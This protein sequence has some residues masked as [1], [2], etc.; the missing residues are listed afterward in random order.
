M[1]AKHAILLPESDP[2]KTRNV[3]D[4]LPASGWDSVVFFIKAVEIRLRFI[5]ILI[6][7][8]LVIGYWETITNYWEKFTRSS[9]V[10]SALADGM[11]F[12]CPM[13]PNVVR[14]TLDPDGSVPDC[15]ICGMPLSKRKK[16]EPVKL[17]EGVLARVQLSPD[18]IQAGGIGSV[19]VE[20]KPL[21]K[22]LRTVGT[23]EYD[24]SRLS[25]IVARVDGY[26]EKLYVNES[27]AELR[28][29][30][31]IADIY[32]PE[33]YTAVQEL[34]LARSAKNEQLA[35]LA[36]EK[37]RL[38][39]IDDQDIDALTT[40]KDK[41]R[42]TLRSPRG[43]HLIRKEVVEGDKV[44]PG[45]VLF[46]VADL[47]QMW[48]EMEVY[49][50]DIAI[51]KPGMKVE[52]RIEAFPERVFPGGIE[53][54]HP[55]LQGDQRTVRV[56][57]RLDNS[58]HLLRQGMYATV[59]VVSPLLETEPF[60]SQLVKSRQPQG[61]VDDVALAAMQKVCPVTGF[62]LGSMGDPKRVNVGTR[63]VLLCCDGCMK[64]M[65]A[66][67]AE[68]L[69]R[70][71][72]VS[73][74]GVLAVPERA[75]IDTG[76]QK[77]VYVEREPGTFEGIEVKLGPRSGGYYA[78]IEGLLPGD[79]VAASGAFLIDAE[80]RLNP[81]ASAAYFGA[82]GGPQSGTTGAATAEPG[83]PGMR[84]LPSA[85]DLAQIGKLP[86]ADRKAATAQ[87]TCPITDEPL[88]SMG[89]PV[90]VMLEGKAVYLCC[91]GCVKK[92]ES[93]PKKTLD[94]IQGWQKE[95]TP[96]AAPAPEAT[97]PLAR[98]L[99]AAEDLTEIA[100]LP[101]ADRKAALAQGTCPITDEPLG[102][103]GVPLK[104]T[105]NGKAVY[106]CCKG[107]EKDAENEAKEVLQK[108]EAWKKE[109]APAKAHEGHG[110]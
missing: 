95:P 71:S 14:P 98:K 89:V 12:F 64:Q 48:L 1:S 96:K 97:K 55:H 60:H 19:A 6:G 15:P 41:V 40:S 20:Q 18:R 68:F 22:E 109:P 42:L 88:G 84:K 102:S 54:V 105:L 75:V 76:E 107:C 31:P 94:K 2:E 49:E 50:R 85:A 27:F 16:G 70:L 47:S 36:R 90:K 78:V 34:L 43:G 5:A 82:S 23:L 13:H 32:S 66:Q 77:I 7:M 33:L 93:E 4:S 51:I 61:T 21:V 104:V 63:D 17:R 86:E 28:Q 10:A 35:S 57:A 9:G 72:T 46:E 101:E 37:L 38:L 58:D 103:M 62:K 74:K 87:G 110:K 11:E 67:P 26:L 69:A 44:M 108:L 65:L 45:Q 91:K 59:R 39:R 53:L 29:G 79:K 30:Q 73:E 99:P 83:R 8:G 25:R 52:A 80:T 106:L 92:A 3:E 100:K 24:E 81:A 56:R